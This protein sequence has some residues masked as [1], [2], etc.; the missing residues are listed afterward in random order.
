[1]NNKNALSRIG[2]TVNQIPVTGTDTTD[3][4][5]DTTDIDTNTTVIA[6]VITTYNN[7]QYDK[8]GKNL[9]TK[10]IDR[11]R[12]MHKKG[13]TIFDVGKFYKPI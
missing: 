5:T 9:R 13:N 12:L 10:D 3:T 1:M 2:D 6:A 7:I 4:D 8:G 11:V